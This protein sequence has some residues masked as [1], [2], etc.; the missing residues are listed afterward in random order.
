ME[1]SEPADKRAIFLRGKFKVGF[2][3]FGH[4][5]KALCILASF[6]ALATTGRCVDEEKVSLEARVVSIADGDSFTALVNGRQQKFR[7]FGI[8][9]PEQGMPFYKASKQKL[10][11]LIV[12]KEIQIDLIETDRYGRGVV[13][14]ILSDG[15]DVASEMLRTGFAWHYRQYSNNREY[16]LLERMARTNR[17][18]LWQDKSPLPPWQIRKTRRKSK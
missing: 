1:N 11:S 2:T 3:I 10:S 5:T 9:A 7:I 16:E 8:D 17:I 6:L 14:I 15:K 12:R 18:G 13:R 4:M